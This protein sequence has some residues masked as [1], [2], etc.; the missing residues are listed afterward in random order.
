MMSAGEFALYKA[1]VSHSARYMEFGSGGSTY[2]AANTPKEWL[3][4]VDSSQ[5]WLDN[6]AAACSDLPRQ[7][8]LHHVDI[9]PLAE[10]GY[11]ADDSAHE[12]WPN[13]H[14]E[15]WN[16]PKCSDAD[17]Y[18][19][20]GRFRVACFAQVV[21]RCRPDALIGIHDFASRPAYHRVYEIGRE[22]AATEDMSFFLPRTDKRE[23]AAAILKEYRYN[24]Q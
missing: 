1:F 18:F 21:L 2:V 4:S 16:L 19:V 20:D 13:Y 6:V 5:E 3:I 15:I 22:I 9:G 23:L 11:P 10:W 24:P 12:R 17:L 7:P 8:E 14:S